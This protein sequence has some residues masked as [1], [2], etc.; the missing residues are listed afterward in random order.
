MVIEPRILKDN[1][2]LLRITHSTRSHMYCRYII[3][4]TY[5]ICVDHKFATMF[6]FLR[7]I[8]ST[9]FWLR[10]T[11]DRCTASNHF[12]VSDLLESCLLDILEGGKESSVVMFGLESFLSA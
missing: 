1:A 8:R 3:H 2:I 9:S 7:L 4:I 5:A 6:T 10:W 12:E 11:V